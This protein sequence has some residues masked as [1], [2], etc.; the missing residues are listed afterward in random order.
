MN[1]SEFKLKFN[2]IY[3][4]TKQEML[5]KGKG[6][7]FW[8]YMISTKN[9]VVWKLIFIIKTIYVSLFVY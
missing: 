8:D 5:V 4:D 7:T 6:T 1:I 2:S 9:F 3:W